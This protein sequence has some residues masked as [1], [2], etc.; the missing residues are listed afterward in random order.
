[1]RLKQGN[2]K[3]DGWFIRLNLSVLETRAP[4]GF[5]ALSPERDDKNEITLLQPCETARAI[6]DPHQHTA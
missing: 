5:G 4:G 6:P 1:M 2:P 3:N